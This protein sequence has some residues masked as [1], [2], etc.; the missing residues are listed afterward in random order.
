[1]DRGRVIFGVIGLAAGLMI[2]FIFANSLNRTGAGSATT[3]AAMPG[4]NALPP[5]HP[6]AAV[7]GGQPA[8]GG[9]VPQV[10]E[11]LDRAEK[12]PDNFDAQM[13]AGDLHYRIQR[14]ADAAKFY[15][16]ANRMKPDAT[17]PMVR[18]GNAYFDAEQ[19]EPAEKWYLEALKKNPNDAN[20][21]TDLGLTFYLRTPRD[22]ERAVKEFDAALSIEPD[23]E[24]TLQ[25]LALAYRDGGDKE[26]FE[27]TL[28]KLRKIN[29][30]NPVVVRSAGK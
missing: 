17:E 2:G 5:D 25:N 20:V 28:E 14:F 22:I 29:P 9:A 12:Q 15:E 19:Y 3:S 27:K 4:N 10:A 1:M 16:K 13:A 21:R 8:G 18:A 24:I 7:P 30:N 26:N 11:A 23:K 6:A